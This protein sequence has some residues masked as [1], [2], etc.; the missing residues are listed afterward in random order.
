MGSRHK[1]YKQQQKYS[2]VIPNPSKTSPTH[3]QFIA[4]KFPHF[5][6]YIYKHSLKRTEVY[7]QTIKKRFS[8][9]NHFVNIFN[10]IGLN[11]QQYKLLKSTVDN[12]KTRSPCFSTLRFSRISPEPLELQKIY[13]HFFTSVFKELSAGTEIFQIR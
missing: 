13:L 9:Y 10:L 1:Y 7:L 8:T 2:L 3:N 4:C 12:K 6:L 11:Q 5:L